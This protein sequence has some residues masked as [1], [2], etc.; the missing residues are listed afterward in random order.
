MKKK[1]AFL[2]MGADHDTQKDR[3]C[4]PGRKTD[5]IIRTANNYEEA[6]KIV[7]ELKAE[8][9]GAIELCGAFGKEKAGEL[10]EL[11]GREVAIGYI[12]HD[13]ELDPLFAAF[14]GN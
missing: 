7:L 13:P 3:C 14:F 5:T 12:V 4:F 2:M 6:K 10:A 1:F 9:V 8:G 11:T